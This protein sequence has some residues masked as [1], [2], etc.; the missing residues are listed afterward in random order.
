MDKTLTGSVSC[1]LF[2]WT[3]SCVV[4][5]RNRLIYCVVSCGACATAHVVAADLTVAPFNSTTIA[6]LCESCSELVVVPSP[7]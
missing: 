1:Y 2:V 7:Y 3:L 6:L 5:S 4:N